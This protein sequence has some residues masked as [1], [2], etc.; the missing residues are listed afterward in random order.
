V[1]AFFE[2]FS[3]HPQDIR[4]LI[5]LVTLFHTAVKVWSL[6]V[7]PSES[8]GESLDSRS[9]CASDAKF[10]VLGPRLYVDV[11]LDLLSV[12]LIV[13]VP[14]SR[15]VDDPGVPSYSYV[16]AVDFMVATS[17]C[18]CSSFVE[19]AFLKRGTAHGVNLINTVTFLYVKINERNNYWSGR[20]L[21]A[22]VVNG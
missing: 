4:L 2:L 19:H 16:E 13:L 6:L 12:S 5:L 22:T 15:E 3:L 18:T 10:V 11:G 21:L 1:T 7:G 8:R 14:V 20:Q 17:C 9:S